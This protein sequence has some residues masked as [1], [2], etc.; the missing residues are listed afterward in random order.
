M[1]GVSSTGASWRRQLSG[2]LRDKRATV[3]VVGLGYVAE[4]FAAAVLL[5]LGSPGAAVETARAGRQQLA[6]RHAADRIAEETA[7]L[8]E[9]VLG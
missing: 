7:G 4:A 8:Y 6:E 2:A 3:G 1:P 5:L 9:E